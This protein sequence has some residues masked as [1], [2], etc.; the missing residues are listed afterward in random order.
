MRHHRGVGKLTAPASGSG[1]AQKA[2]GAIT[3]RTLG[4]RSRFRCC[5]LGKNDFATRARKEQLCQ[6][7]AGRDARFRRFGEAASDD[8]VE[9]R[10]D[11]GLELRDGG[12]RRSENAVADALQRICV[13]GARAS[14][15]FVEN[16]AERKDVG[17][18]VLWAAHDLFGAPISWGAEQAGVAGFT[19]GDAGHAKVSELYA[20]VGSDENVGRLDVAVNDAAF[21]RDVEGFRSVSDPGAG[22]R[23]RQRAL[24][25]NPIE[26]NAI[27]K[28]HNEIRRLRGVFDA[29]VMERDDV[30]MG[31]LADDAGF[32]QEKVASFALRDFRREDFDGHG[33]PD[34]GIEAA[35]HAASGADAESFKEL[36]ATDLQG[37]NLSVLGEG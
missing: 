1:G 5:L 18:G 36:V 2:R 10:G 31:K 11:G 22:A 35:N 14:D 37:D 17:A 3:E 26:R 20:T 29:H 32:A 6:C 21:V 12:R 7:F 30:G 19:T 27:D 33:A 34:H 4:R 8:F 23:K 16:D 9:G 13:E 25:E 15:H 24:F 28:F